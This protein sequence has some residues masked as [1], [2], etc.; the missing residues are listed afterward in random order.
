MVSSLFI[1]CARAVYGTYGGVRSRQFVWG[2]RQQGHILKMTASE[3]EQEEVNEERMN[4]MALQCQLRL[5][6]VV[7]MPIATNREAESA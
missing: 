6:K 3:E 5:Q 4:E 1:H 2:L 7:S